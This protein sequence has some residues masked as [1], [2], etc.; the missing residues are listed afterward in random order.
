MKVVH[1]IL[2]V[3]KI[4]DSL[5]EQNTVYSRV[6]RISYVTQNVLTKAWKEDNGKVAKA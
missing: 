1:V 6:Y 5:T 4:S 2:S 3:R